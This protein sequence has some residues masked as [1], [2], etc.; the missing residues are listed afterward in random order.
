MQVKK[1]IKIEPYS[2]TVTVI[3]TDSVNEVAILKGADDKPYSRARAL[4]IGT[5]VFVILPKTFDIGVIAHES[6][7]AIHFVFQ[8]SGVHADRDND[9][10]LC[11]HVQYLV[12]KIR[13]MYLRLEEKK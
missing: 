5:D 11:Y 13:N 8:I 3:I 7:H 12:Y 1:R 6:I 4:R 2:P 9:E 10:H